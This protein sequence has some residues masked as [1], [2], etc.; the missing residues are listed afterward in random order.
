MSELT[1]DEAEAVRSWLERHQFEH[2]S[3]VGGDSAAFG[4]RQ[5][6]WEREWHPVP[7]HSGS[8]PMV[9]RH[10]TR[11]G[12]SLARRG[13]RCRGDG[14]EVDYSRRA[15]GGPGVVDR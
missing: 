3:T 1:V 4:D 9:V 11:R 14:L 13:R 6:I 2:V 12:G 10:L 15:R 8:W 7:T 5:D